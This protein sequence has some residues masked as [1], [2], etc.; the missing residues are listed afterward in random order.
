MPHFYFLGGTWTLNGDELRIRLVIPP[1]KDRILVMQ[2]TI[3]LVSPKSDIQL[4]PSTFGIP[5]LE[6]RKARAEVELEDVI[7]CNGD[8][9]VEDAITKDNRVEVGTFSLMK[10]NTHSDPGKFTITIPR[11]IRN[12]D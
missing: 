1:G 12:Q 8:V 10:I 6:A 3:Q 4:A 7:Y 2:G 9:W 5:A 11:P